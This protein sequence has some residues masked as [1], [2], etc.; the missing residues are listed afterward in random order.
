MWNSLR[1]GFKR[2]L[3]KLLIAA[4]FYQLAEM[5]P[6][7]WGDVM[8]PV[9]RNVGLVAFFAACADV[10]V[11]IFQ[12]YVDTEK[13]HNI[14]R[15]KD[16][17]DGAKQAAARVYLGRCF[18]FIGILFAFV[19][20]AKAA[21]VQELPIKQVSVNPYIVSTF[22]R[23]TYSGGENA[24]VAKTRSSGHMLRTQYLWAIEP[25]TARQ[26]KR[27][28]GLFLLAQNERE[29]RELNASNLMRVQLI[30]NA[31]A[32]SIT[33]M[34][35][36]ATRNSPILIRNVHEYWP[37]LKQMSL[38]AAQIE[39]ETCGRLSSA[40]C[41]TSNARL[42]VVSRNGTEDGAGFGQLTRVIRPS[43]Q[44]RFDN[45]SQMRLKY[46]KQLANYGWQ[47][48]ND[49]Q[50]SM[51]AYVLFMRDTCKQVPR[52]VSSEVDRFQMCLSGYNGGMGGLKEDILSCRATQGC[53]PGKWAGNVEMTSAK[54][55]TAVPGYGQSAYLINRGYV[56]NVT[57]VRRVR[58]LSLDE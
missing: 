34:P 15:D 21:E 3:M 20:G 42:H 26:Q 38:T 25:V 27:A 43:G 13:L 55:K 19:F 16:E 5:F 14:V 2:I 46:P 41:W 10:F 22:Y 39:Q 54:S 48:W 18:L 45:L 51:T 53:N 24:I 4:L 35:V 11:R 23:D 8:A 52:T 47:N 44:T 9:M 49:P 50:L 31:K 40:T 7:L 12:P 17:S 57:V 36:N 30:A 6:L 33:S 1:R 56:S 28:Q 58:Y 37:E 32:S 29:W